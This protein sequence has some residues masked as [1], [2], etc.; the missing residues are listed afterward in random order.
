MNSIRI[1]LKV[2]FAVLFSESDEDA[3]D[4]EESG[5]GADESD[6]HSGSGADR[7]GQPQRSFYNAPAAPPEFDY[8]LTFD[9][10]SHRAPVEVVTRRMTY[11]SRITVHSQA[12]SGANCH[13]VSAYQVLVAVITLRSVRSV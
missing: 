3:D 6:H 4:A 8:G 9:V 5:S 11:D 10:V 1:A 2:V 7:G 13:V 12:S